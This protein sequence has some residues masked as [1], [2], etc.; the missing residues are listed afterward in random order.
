MVTPILP[1][2]LQDL[3]LRRG[4]RRILGPISLTIK[5]TGLTIVMGHNGAGKTS[6]LKAMHGLEK[7]NRGVVAWRTGTDMARGRQAFLF[8]SPII[9]RRSVADC[10][11]YPL[12]LQGVRRAA[13]RDKAAKQA[14]RV[15]LSSLLDR[16]ADV[17]SAGEKQKL[18]LARAFIGGPEILFLDEPCASLDIHSAVEIETIL[19]AALAAGTRMV[20]TTHDIAQ[21]RR[22]ATEVVYLQDGRLCEHTPAK[23]FF[24]KPRSLEARAHLNGELTS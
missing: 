13:A 10:I 22:L 24:D 4:G 9:M 1:L 20:M 16:P 19:K 5:G 3:E 15:G 8:Q 21:A 14:E 11:A 6:L 7:V 18:A 23:I 17:L 12:R 2:V